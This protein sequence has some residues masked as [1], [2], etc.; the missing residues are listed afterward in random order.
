[1]SRRDALQQHALAVLQQQRVQQ[2]DLSR[3][4]SAV[5]QT[6]M[7]TRKGRQRSLDV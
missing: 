2:L 5:I 3:A 4:A 1:V 7:V 6:M